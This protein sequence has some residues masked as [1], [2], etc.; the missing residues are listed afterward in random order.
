MLG[1]LSLY[2]AGHPNRLDACKE[3]AP[4]PDGL[5]LLVL[6][7]SLPP[8]RADILRFAGATLA[9]IAIR[10]TSRVRLYD[11]LGQEGPLNTPKR[12]DR[13]YSS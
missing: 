8:P 5:P 1:T 12:N 2:I 9:S 7:D 6:V 13:F 10:P 11:A 3:V 4:P